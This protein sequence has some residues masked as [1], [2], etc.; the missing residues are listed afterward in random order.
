MTLQSSGQISIKDIATEFGH[1]NY[2][3]GNY[4]RVQSI[5]GSGLGN[6]P[7]DEGIPTSG[8]ISLSDFYGKRLNIVVDC[9]SGGEETT[10]NV[11]NE[12]WNNN[13]TTVIGNFGKSRKEGG[14]KIIVAVNKTFKSEKNKPVTKC[15]LR[16]G[17]WNSTAQIVVEVAGSG[18]IYGAGGNGG[19]GGWNSG[20]INY[21]TTPPS[22]PQVPGAPGGE[23]GGALGVES[24]GTVVNV[25]SGGLILAGGGGGGGGGGQRETSGWG[26]RDGS[27][28]GGGGGLGF[29][30]G[31]GGAGGVQSNAGQ[32][33]NDGKA[34][35]SIG[36]VTSV[37]PYKP[38]YYR[39]VRS[40]T[41]GRSN[42]GGNN[43]AS[44][45]VSINGSGNIT[46]VT[47]AR[48]FTKEG[49]SY[50]ARG[51]RFGGQNYEVGQTVILVSDADNPFSGDGYSTTNVSFNITAIG[52]GFAGKGGENGGQAYGARGGNGGDYG[53]TGND[54]L[55]G[56]VF[57]R[58]GAASPYGI[59]GAGGAA[60][61]AIRRAAGTSFTIGTNNG[62]ITGST[63]QTG[64]Q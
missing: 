48:R 32:P 24:N 13:L 19:R 40:N 52:G 58:H 45:E 35:T 63:N 20:R 62:T 17:T 29:P 34:I 39:K 44:F 7:V 47:I 31:V 49:S 22:D 38:G 28:G 5:A 10:T 55:N 27:G 26:A 25:R 37:G 6:L 54:G 33:G 57:D 18:K 1:L 15:A 56:N 14:S 64:V 16:T 51:T 59:G 3:L 60:G 61:G 50:Y 43:D 9:F 2:S 42:E 23:G 46:S 8:Q 4:R 11:K 53:A 41:P 36:A 21:N 12:K 30:P